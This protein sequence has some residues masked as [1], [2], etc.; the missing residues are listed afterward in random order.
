MSKDT[1][2]ARYRPK[3]LR[4]LPT[5]VTGVD[6]DGTEACAEAIIEWSAGRFMLDD[7][8]RLCALTPDGLR[9]VPEGGTAVLG[10][11]GE[12]YMLMPDVKAVAYREV[13]GVDF[14]APLTLERVRELAV[15]ARQA[16]SDR[17]RDIVAELAA[18]SEAWMA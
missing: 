9:Y 16:G 10:V 7:Y 4:H 2:K 3:R 8:G 12:P 15:E 6:F 18:H 1:T 13:D 5:V 17:L 11:V 14:R